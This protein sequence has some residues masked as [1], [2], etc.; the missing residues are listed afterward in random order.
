[1]TASLPFHLAA[2]G[3]LAW[4][5]VTTLRAHPVSPAA[6]AP[7]PAAAH[8]RAFTSTIALTLANPATIA[9]FAAASTA[10][11]VGGAAP[12]AALAFAGAVLA[13]S[14]T[15]WTFLSASVSALR[16]RLGPR[17]LRAVQLA[18]GA[19]LLGFAALAVHP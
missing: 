15:W 19:A 9:S 7:P 8:A 13:G 1:M 10:I 6:T 5:G 3:I 14:A 12:R 11:G 2:A 17:T 18:A 16:L 4:L